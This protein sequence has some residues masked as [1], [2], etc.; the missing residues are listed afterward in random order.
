M[1]ASVAMVTQKMFSIMR[2]GIQ[3]VIALE[4]SMISL[5]R[6]Y[7]VTG[8]SMES[9]QNK[10]I[11]TSRELATNA[12]DYID[13]VTSFK[14]LGYTISEAQTLATQT[15]KFNLAGDINNME[16]ATTDVVSTL[17]GFKMEASEVNRVIDGVNATSNEYAVTSQDLANIL[18]K[19]ASSLSVFGNDLE[20]SISLGTVANEILQDSDKVGR[21][22]KLG[23]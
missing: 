16:E 21:S 13:S 19:S 22:L 12:T 7:D 17:K 11:A 14:K 10:L 8:E 20:E 18:Q 15:T 9:F 4:D 23:A 5:Q 2:E 6:V 1:Y 3:D